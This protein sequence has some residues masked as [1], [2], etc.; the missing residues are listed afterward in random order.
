MMSRRTAQTTRFGLPSLVSLTLVCCTATGC[1]HKTVSAPNPFEIDHREY[2]RMH[3]AAVLVLRDAGFD[4]VLADH[5]YGRVMTGYSAS[6][7]ALEPWHAPNTTEDQAVESTLNHQR[8]RVVI[9]FEPIGQRPTDS[10]GPSAIRAQPDSYHLR[11]EVAI[12]RRRVPHRHLTGSTTHTRL[13]GLGKGS[14]S[15]PLGRGQIEAYWQGVGRDVHLE[16]RLI[17]RIVELSL[18]LDPTQ[19][20][21]SAAIGPAVN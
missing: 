19:P 2:S 1:A 21:A 7:T 15:G 18:K 20:V 6:P 11:A 10:G 16:Q 12:E 9:Y 3:R 8:R 5:R 14:Q 13:F 17:A 4:V